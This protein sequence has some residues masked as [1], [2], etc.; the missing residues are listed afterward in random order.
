MGEGGG[1]GGEGGGGLMVPMVITMYITYFIHS[2]WCII[3]SS[4]L[5]LLILE[6]LCNVTETCFRYT[7][8]IRF[9]F[10]YCWVYTNYMSCVTQKG[11]LVKLWCNWEM[12]SYYRSKK[13]DTCLHE[14]AFCFTSTWKVSEQG[15]IL[16]SARNSHWAIQMM[17]LCKIREVIFCLSLA[18][19][20]YVTLARN[21]AASYTLCFRSHKKLILTAI[22]FKLSQINL[23][24]MYI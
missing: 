10:T 8:I 12:T 7:K 19:Y 3:R 22:L 15:K 16:K 13:I 9:F 2:K 1:G 21:D 5:L 24:I 14:S 17:F 20:H 6:Y 11:P 23:K 18:K 4:C